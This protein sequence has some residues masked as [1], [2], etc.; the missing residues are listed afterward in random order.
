M[1]G[2]LFSRPPTTQEAKL[3]YDGRLDLLENKYIGTL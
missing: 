3:Y 2:E 1:F